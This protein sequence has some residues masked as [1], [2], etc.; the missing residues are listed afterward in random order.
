LTKTLFE[1][2]VLASYPQIINPLSVDKQKKK[3]EKR[4]KEKGRDN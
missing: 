2:I 1:F 4:K 3:R